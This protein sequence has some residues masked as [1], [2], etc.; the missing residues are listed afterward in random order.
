MI[1][2]IFL[3]FAQP[4]ISIEIPGRPLFEVLAKLEPLAHEKLIPS[5]EIKHL[6]LILRIKDQPWAEVKKQIAW[7]TWATWVERDGSWVLERTKANRDDYAVSQA[8]RRKLYLKA[9][10]DGVV[11]RAQASGNWKKEAAVGQD[12]TDREFT[13]NFRVNTWRLIAGIGENGLAQSEHTIWCSPARSNETPFP[14]GCQAILSEILAEVNANRRRTERSVPERNGYQLATQVVLIKDGVNSFS[15]KVADQF[16]KIVASFGDSV[17]VSSLIPVRTAKSVPVELSPLTQDW[18]AVRQVNAQATAVLTPR[19]QSALLDPV[20]TDPCEL[21]AGPILTEIGEGLNVNVVATITPGGIFRQT[22]QLVGSIKSDSFLNGLQAY[23][24]VGVANNWL[25]VRPVIG[26]HA[27]TIDRTTLKQD[28]NDAWNAKSDDDRAEILFISASWPEPAAFELIASAFALLPGTQISDSI[29]LMRLFRG[30]R[31]P[32]LK[33]VRLSPEERRAVEVFFRERMTM[34]RQANAP[35]FDPKSES[36]A[37]HAMTSTGLETDLRFLPTRLYPNGIPADIEVEFEPAIASGP[38]RVRMAFTETMVASK[39]M[40]PVHYAMHLR[41]LKAGSTT[42]AYKWFASPGSAGGKIIYRIPG[43]ADLE[44]DASVFAPS[45]KP[46]VKPIS[47]LPEGFL[48]QVRYYE[49]MLP[50]GQ[51]G[52]GKPPPR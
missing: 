26:E 6:P 9:F 42:K 15:L 47:E 5:A 32:F 7:A 38:T 14:S 33:Q 4:A 8:E 43:V 16:G 24:E 40:Y 28:L 22:R 44:T 12:Q 41:E 27:L 23:S 18:L 20:K 49:M 45:P 50:T 34:V 52:A 2:A 29:P 19:L 51:G 13:G 46:V 21:V 25:R 35:R 37:V 1:S 30:Q 39:L 17:A 48:R 36:G 3:T 10:F 11:K 31:E